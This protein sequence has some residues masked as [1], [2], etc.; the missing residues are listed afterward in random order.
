[1]HHAVRVHR[2]ARYD[3]RPFAPAELADRIRAIADD[4]AAP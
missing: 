1:M 3:G 2:V 4:G